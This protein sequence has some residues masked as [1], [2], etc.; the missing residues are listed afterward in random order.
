[1]A[2][3]I[4]NSG[5]R[6]FAENST[7]NVTSDYNGI[8]RDDETWKNY[9]A[10]K[11]GLLPGDFI[12]SITL[13]TA[14]RQATFMSTLLGEALADSGITGQEINTSSVSNLTSW[15][16]PV[17]RAIAYGYNLS[18]NN[19]KI[20]GNF[21]GTFTAQ[22]G[23]DITN[24]YGTVIPVP[25]N[26]YRFNGYQNLGAHTLVSIMRTNDGSL[27]FRENDP[28][29]PRGDLYAATL[30]AQYGKLRLHV[31]MTYDNSDNLSAVDD[32][33]VT[34][35]ELKQTSWLS[36]GIKIQPGTN[37]NSLTD[38]GNYYALNDTNVSNIPLGTESK[39]FTL[40]VSSVPIGSNSYI[41]QQFTQCDNGNT[42][43]R[44]RGLDDS[45]GGGWSVTYN[46]NT[47]A[48]ID[49]TRAEAINSG[50]TESGDGTHKI[51]VPVKALI[52]CAMNHY[53]TRACL[54]VGGVDGTLETNP[55]YFGIQIEGLPKLDD[56]LVHIDMKTYNS[57]TWITLEQTKKT[58][59]CFYNS[60]YYSP[61]ING[62]PNPNYN[63]KP[64]WIYVPRAGDRTQVSTGEAIPDAPTGNI[65]SAAQPVYLT[66]GVL[67]P[68]TYATVVDSSLPDKPDANTLYFI[69]EN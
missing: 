5:F 45:W 49:F 28:T 58:Y 21:N 8:Y 25:E 32:R 55:S 51:M 23:P 4:Y 18:T 27:I 37:L 26:C 7:T 14:L 41:Q 38:I 40:K 46:T 60:N 47:A 43:T 6:V 64:I 42:Y 16:T 56:F 1:M 30:N 31:G 69:T 11:S 68:C 36:A 59:Q 15:V 17:S 13:N 48:I 3:Y 54:R 67:T 44:I 20:G 50:C 39:A 61:T 19:V 9:D 24:E 53:S 22:F 62:E 65:G 29:D 66:D 52:Q 35:Q 2:D 57:D 34:M 12:S 10:R 63:A 33:I